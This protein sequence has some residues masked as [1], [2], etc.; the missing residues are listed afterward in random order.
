[1][2][3]AVDIGNTNI[4]MSFHDGKQWGRTWRIHTD[5][6]KTS[7]EYLVIMETLWENSG[8]DRTAVRHAAIS[9]V[10]PNLTRAIQK[11]IQRIFSISPLML[12][13]QVKTGLDMSTVPS[14]IGQ[15]IMCNL[16]AAHQM[17][18][19]RVAMTL[20]CGTA[21]TF[22]TVDEKGR[23]LGVAI[24]PGL[25]TAVN[26]LFGNTAQLPQVELKIPT[27]VLGR[28]TVDS[29]RAGIMLGYIEMID[30][31]IERTEK[32]LGKKIAVIATG[33]LSSTIASEIPRIDV[34]A[35]NHTLDGLRLIS[36]MN[37]E[38]T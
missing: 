13:M 7:D 22:S 28:N 32:E 36:E 3:L 4:V 33:G 14:E 30:G 34:L 12:S 35:P 15:D 37:R 11:D 1:M 23:V 26:A 38:T 16:A 5:T 24:L 31:M 19:D 29:I 9:S 27:S 18:P 17:F 25:V 20:D 8:F 2:F 10:V 21:M 6:K